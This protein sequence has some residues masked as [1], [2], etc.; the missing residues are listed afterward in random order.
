LPACGVVQLIE[1][2]ETGEPPGVSQGSGSGGV[3]TPQRMRPVPK[4][5]GRV[6]GL[7]FST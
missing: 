4:G 2:L 5:T 7:N 3:D 1:Q 6:E